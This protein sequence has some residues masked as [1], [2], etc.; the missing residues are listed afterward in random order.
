MLEK[1]VKIITKRGARFICRAEDP[2][3][4]Q[5]FSCKSPHRR[6]PAPSHLLAMPESRR[7]TEWACGNNRVNT[8]HWGGSVPLARPFV[9][10]WR[11]SSRSRLLICRET[12]LV[13]VQPSEPRRLAQPGQ[14]ACFGSRTSGVRISHLRPRSLSISRLAVNGSCLPSRLSRVRIPPGA[15]SS[16]AVAKWSCLRFLIGYMSVRVRPA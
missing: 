8:T 4:F 7:S 14:S 1:I 5:R 15:P 12:L 16:H 2:A 3:S 9:R 6:T 11:N 13:R 10:M